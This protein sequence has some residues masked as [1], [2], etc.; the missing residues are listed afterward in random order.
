MKKHGVWMKN[1]HVE[2]VILVWDPQASVP[3]TA[4]THT[5]G[6]AVLG[7]P[8]GSLARRH[9]RNS[10]HMFVYIVVCACS[11]HALDFKILF[12]RSFVTRKDYCVT[13]SRS[14]DRV[15]TTA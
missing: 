1:T 5:G 2:F 3:S 14:L 10:F 7:K 6:D 13:I 11:R 4:E 9:P 12:F 15:N 8:G